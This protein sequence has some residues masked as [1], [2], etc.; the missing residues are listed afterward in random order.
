[1]KKVFLL[2]AM[3]LG[4][5]LNAQYL[6]NDAFK[7][8]TLYIPDI[9]VSGTI[10][11]AFS[12]VDHFSSFVIE[13][14]TPN[15]TLT[16]PTPTDTT[17]GDDVTIRNTGSAAFTMY[18]INVSDSFDIHLT[19]KRGSW[20]PVGSTGGSGAGGDACGCCDSLLYFQN[21]TNAHNQN[22]FNKGDY[23]LL[24]NDNTYGWAWGVLRQIKQDVGFQ[25]NDSDGLVIGI[26]TNVGFNG[27]DPRCKFNPPVNVLAY[28][29]NDTAAI[30]D[31]LDPLDYY[32]L[33]NSNTYGMQKGTIK[34]ITE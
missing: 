6:L 14:T 22:W 23:Y 1:M 12:T 34:Q 17:W 20:L 15:I 18:G 11:D 31:G 19:W 25:I 10:G 9:T 21:D 32:L 26:D 8:V 13:Q 29:D 4:L 16:L 30:A 33:S 24:S 28:Y 27:R 3:F 7:K 5:S 2:I